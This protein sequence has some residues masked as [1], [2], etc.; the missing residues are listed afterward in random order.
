MVALVGLTAAAVEVLTYRSLETSMVPALLERTMS[1]AKLMAA[2]FA[3]YVRGARADVLSFRSAPS[4]EGIMRARVSAGGDFAEGTSE[5]IWRKRLAAHLV[6]ELEAKPAYHQ[7]RFIGIEDAGRELVRVDRS[8]PNGA[9]RVVPDNELQ[10]KGDRDYFKQTIETPPGHVYV[11]AIDLN[12]EHGVVETPHV[13]TLRVA[14]LISEPDNRPFGILM[15]NLDMRPIF[16]QLRS[17]ARTDGH[18]FVANDRGDY[19]VHSD[20]SREFAFEVGGTSRWS[21]EFPELATMLDANTAGRSREISS[22][23]GERFI[24]AMAPVQFAGA[25]RAAIIETVPYCVIQELIAPVRYSS[26]LAG[27]L[28]VLGAIVLAVLLARSLARPLAEMT[29][30]VQKF[31]REGTTIESIAAGGEIGVLARAFA[32]MTAEIGDK[33]EALKQETAERRRIFE[34]SLDLILVVD[35][36]GQCL[37]VSPSSTSILGYQPEE[38]IGRNAAEFIYPDDLMPTRVEMRSARRGH[39]KSSFQSRYI[40][41]DGRVVTLMWTGVWSEPEQQHFFFGRDL[42]EQKEVEENFRLAVESCPS[43][44]VM[45]D[46]AGRMV[47]VNTEIE[48]QFGYR[49]DELIGQPVELL[50][51]TRMRDQHVEER[52]RFAVQP[53]TRRMGAGRDLFGL[54]K[55]GTEFPVEVGLNP[56]HARKGLLVLGVIVDI[57]SRKIAEEKFRLAVES[58]PSGMVMI[59]ADGM[60]LLVNAETEKLFGY[61]REEL[62]GH[63]VDMLVPPRFRDQHPQHCKAFGEHPRARLMGAGRDL[64]GLRKDGTEF[65]VEVGLNPIQTRDGLVVLSVVIDI[66][67]RKRNERLKDEFVSTVSHELR[68]PLTSIAASL[69]L[70]TGTADD[71][72]PATTRRLINIAHSNSQRLVRLINDILDIE[73][74]ESGKVVFNLRRVEV[75]ALI[76]QTIEANRGLADEYGVKLRLEPSSAQEVRADPDRLM[77]VITNLLS[78]A[79]KFSPRE[80]EVTVS[81]EGRD[82]DVRIGVRDHGPGIPDSFRSQIF[83]KFAQADA[84]DARQKGGTGLGLSIAKQIVLRLGGE[85]GFT[86]APGGG[87][88]FFVDLPCLDAAGEADIEK[89]ENFFSGR[90]LLCEDDREAAAVMRDRL[91]LAGF[92]TDLAHNAA[93]AIAQ[94]AAATYAAILVDLQLPD[95]DGISLIQQLR[96]QPQYA[97]TPIV[98][99]SANPGRGREDLRSSNLNILGWLSKPLDVALLLR[100]LHPTV[101]RNGSTRLHILHIDDDPNVLAVVAQA[102]DGDALVVS[103]ATIEEARRALAASHFDLVVMDL[104]LD[105][106]PGLDL[107]AE[108]HDSAGEAI[109]VIVYSARGANAACAAQVQAALTKSRASIDNLIATLRRRLVIDPV[110]TVTETETA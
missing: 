106:S 50:V 60:I 74:I 31:G 22:S 24:A 1:H 105:G 82:Q 54:R 29:A 51:P 43:G 17:S 19:L 5:I 35:R 32:S 26:L 47:M 65:P 52:S 48:N 11:S 4:I 71:K 91:R 61:P 30:A 13:P 88:M 63:S 45:I 64:F 109:P 57:T 7:F 66:S 70:L 14:T 93:D 102:L 101:V 16:E 10:R 99:V 20:P 80:A 18:I 38:M 25:V 107:L 44:M 12:Q 3:G 108:L 104:V 23:T 58:C 87:T 39:L 68:T 79:I 73:K 2:Q 28:A 89:V 97:E 96:S 103:V 84:S 34:T 100:T 15:I 27:L 36:Q 6:G 94:A 83:Q 77:Q 49:R 67:E 90:L 72:L 9:V 21:D 40:H 98:V 78:N 86:D 76:E 53:E 81:V 69:G 110:R 59:N 55:D 56:I 8:G 41:K 62:I 42:T 85:I 33:T 95:A 92:S 37:Q 46:S 75:L